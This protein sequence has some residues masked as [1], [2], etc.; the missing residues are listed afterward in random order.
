MTGGRVVLADSYRAEDLFGDATVPIV[1]ACRADVPM[2]SNTLR[3]VPD[4]HGNL[5]RNP[6]ALDELEGVLTASRVVVRGD[7]VPLRVEVPELVLAGQAI[8]VQAQVADGS[9]QGLLI[10][11]NDESGQF[12][13]S[14]Q[15]RPTKGT[16]ATTLDSL[17]PGAYTIDVAGLNP[18]SP[19]AP[20]SS[21]VLV[22]S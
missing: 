6:A 3:R 16:S 19:V 12:V 17:P 18:A 13:D 1:G 22:W 14:Y 7:V 10:T 15:P 21:D 11:V 4:K 20:V 9:R 2:N 5:H 8:P